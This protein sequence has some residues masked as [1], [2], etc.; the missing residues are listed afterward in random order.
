[1][2]HE[3]RCTPHGTKT[4]SCMVAWT[5]SCRG[6][7]SWSARSRVSGLNRPYNLNSGLH[8]LC[9]ASVTMRPPNFSCMHEHSILPK[10]KLRLFFLI[11]LIDIDSLRYRIQSSSSSLDKLQVTQCAYVIGINPIYFLPSG[12]RLEQSVHEV[13]VI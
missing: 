10:K 1:M 5:I 7:R 6:W 9:T 2:K 3:C 13:V 11:C 12:A 4:Y 8:W